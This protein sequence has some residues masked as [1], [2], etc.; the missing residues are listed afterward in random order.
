MRRGSGGGYGGWALALMFCALMC[1][2]TVARAETSSTSKA[3]TPRGGQGTTA[4]QA[5]STQPAPPQGT[6]SQQTTPSSDTQSSPPDALH[7]I[8]VTFDYDFTKTPPCSTKKP[9][10]PCA[11]HFSIFE[12]TNGT[13]KKYRVPLF[14]V[15][16]PAKPQG[17]KTVT[18][19]SPQ[20][21]DLVLGWHKLSVAAVDPVNGDSTLYFCD[22]CATWIWVQVGPTPTPSTP[23]PGSSTMPPGVT[24]PSSTPN[25][26]PAPAP[27]TH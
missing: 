19:K 15:P 26:T 12:T 11:D 6:S 17:K 18:Q 5:T 25:S 9:V 22:S 7:F 27:P 13:K 14:D 4:Q 24:P 20:Q 2:A 16:L 1:A 8:T 21:I 23:V 10:H 3:Q